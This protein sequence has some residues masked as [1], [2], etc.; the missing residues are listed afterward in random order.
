MYVCMY[1]CMYVVH[2]WITHSFYII[3]TFFY[4]ILGVTTLDIVRANTFVADA[5]VQC[6]NQPT[7]PTNCTN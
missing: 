4:S 5:K 2:V 7:F 3:V 6:R 1:V